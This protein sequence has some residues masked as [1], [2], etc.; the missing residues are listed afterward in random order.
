MWD[1]YQNSIFIDLFSVFCCVSLLIRYGGLRFS[2][3]GVPYLFFHVHTVTSRLFALADGAR[4]LFSGGA[5]WG[6]EPSELTRAALYLDAALWLVTLVWCFMPCEDRKSPMN[7][8]AMRIDPTVHRWMVYLTVTIG[9]FG[10]R[11]LNLPGYEQSL[12]N[13]AWGNSSYL[14]ILPTWFGLGVLAHIYLHGANK[15]TG[16]LISVYLGLM[17]MQGQFRFRI[18]TAVLMLVHIWVERRERR[19]PGLPLL[20]GLGILAVLFFPMKDIGARIL[21]GDGLDAL[22]AS[23]TE[24]VLDVSTGR[25]ADQGFLDQAAAA[26]TLGDAKG[27]KLWFAGYVPFLTL[28]IP[29]AWWP[30]KPTLADS[31][32]IGFVSR[33]SRPMKLNGMVPTYVGEAYIDFGAFG[34]VFVAPILLAM[35]LSWFSRKAMR[36]PYDSVMRLTYTMVSVNLIQVYRDGFTSLFLFTTVNMMPLFFLIV[37]HLVLRAFQ[38]RQRVRGFELLFRASVAAEAGQPGPPAQPS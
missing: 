19:W 26:M 9:A 36:T 35:F 33:P 25:A 4:P 14:W 17:L 11:Y 22:T 27:E 1:E 5:F 20:F 30:D 15:L 12:G 31:G 7:M 24:S 38:S 32:A 16:L 8:E 10:L 37:A 18:V 29:R 23:V 28:P 13:S 34:G 3:P 21:R 2:H 6:V